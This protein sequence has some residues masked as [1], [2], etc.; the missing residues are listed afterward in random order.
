MGQGEG[1]LEMRRFMIILMTMVS[2]LLWCTPARAAPAVCGPRQKIAENLDRKHQEKPRYRALAPDG[3][4]MLE[5]FVSPAGT[6]SILVVT[7]NK[8]AC[9]A[10]T[11]K[12][13]SEA[14]PVIY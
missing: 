1:V 7:P 6:F 2:G 3:K 8:Q 5:V 10:I 4:A 9:F 11:G 12:D 13:W 14:P